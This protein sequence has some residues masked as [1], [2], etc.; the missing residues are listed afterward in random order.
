MWYQNRSELD[1]ISEAGV[2]HYIGDNGNPIVRMNASFWL[3]CEKD[4]T[5]F[6][7][8][9]IQTGN[10]EAW[11]AVA[12]MRELKE[13][14]DIYKPWFI[15]IGANNGYYT[16]M[17][18]TAR[19][20]TLAFEPNPIL[21]DMVERS[22]S[23]NHSVDFD[24]HYI[25][26]SDKEGKAKLHQHPNHSGASSLEGDESTESIEV[27]TDLLDNYYCA[28]EEN[29][30]VVLK[31][32]V[33]GHE[34]NVWNGAKKIREATNN[35]WFLEWVPVRHGK[36]YNREWLTEVLETHDLQ[37]VNY[38]GTLRPVGIEEALEVEFETIVFRKR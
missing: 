8:P 14:D 1:R 7:Q 28:Y 19:Y 32:D 38:D 24:I 13:L 16:L 2:Y 6:T 3:E 25:A 11:L 29:E 26:L 34:R 30:P 18:N 12:I 9:A 4:D 17:A 35:V 20:P 33:E 10:W 21:A 23:L 37:M 27:E 5:A 22:L 36:D 15:D 31:V